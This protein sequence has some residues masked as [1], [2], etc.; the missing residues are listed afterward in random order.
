M[1]PKFQLLAV[2]KAIPPLNPHQI[3]QSYSFQFITLPVRFLF[4]FRN[5]V[6]NGTAIN[7]AINVYTIGRKAKYQSIISSCQNISIISTPISKNSIDSNVLDITSKT[8]DNI[9]R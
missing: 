5:T 2:E 7:L 6:Y 1:F 8:S 9:W 3:K 4:I